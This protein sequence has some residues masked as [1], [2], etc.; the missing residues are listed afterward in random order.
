MKGMLSLEILERD[1]DLSKAE[2]VLSLGFRP[3]KAN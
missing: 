2:S 1:A 3:A